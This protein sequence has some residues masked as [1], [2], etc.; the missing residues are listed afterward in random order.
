MINHYYKIEASSKSAWAYFKS[1]QTFKKEYKANKTTKQSTECRGAGEDSCHI[2]VGSGNSKLGEPW[3]PD[4]IFQESFMK[5]LFSPIFLKVPQSPKITPP[6]GSKQ[7]LLH[8][9][10]EGI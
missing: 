2:A 5:D 7:A 1:K 10:V 3:G 4:S 9:T 6:I 8:K